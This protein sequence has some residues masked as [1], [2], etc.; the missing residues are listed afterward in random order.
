MWMLPKNKDDLILFQKLL[1]T[2]ISLLLGCDMQWM[3]PFP[4]AMQIAVNSLAQFPL[5]HLQTSVLGEGIL[6]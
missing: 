1:I 6:L 3:G 5:A 2:D 4:D